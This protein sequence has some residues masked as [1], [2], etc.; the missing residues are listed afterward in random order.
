MTV[1]NL[2]ARPRSTAWTVAAAA[3]GSVLLALVVVAAL[4][5]LDDLAGAVH[6]MA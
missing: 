5:A 1:R 2:H 3:G 4:D 6:L